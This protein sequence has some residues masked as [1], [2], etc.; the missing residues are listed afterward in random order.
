[1]YVQYKAALADPFKISLSI[2]SSGCN[3][4]IGLQMFLDRLTSVN[5]SSAVI[6]REES[7]ILH[8]FEDQ[9]N[10]NANPLLFFLIFRVLHSIKP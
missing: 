5:C 3:L 8:F 10:S 2:A 9:L 6:L 1:M 4:G 7:L